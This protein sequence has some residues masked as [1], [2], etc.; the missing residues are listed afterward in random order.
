MLSNWWH[1]IPRM[2]S[3]NIST[4]TP[5]HISIPHASFWYDVLVPTIFSMM[6]NGNLYIVIYDAFSFN[7]SGNFGRPNLIELLAAAVPRLIIRLTAFCNLFRILITQKGSSLCNYMLPF[8]IP[9]SKFMRLYFYFY[10]QPIASSYIPSFQKCEKLVV[11][12][13]VF[14]FQ[15]E[16]KLCSIN[17]VDR[18]E[19]SL[20][21]RQMQLTTISLE[22]RRLPYYTKRA[23]I[24]FK[25][26]PI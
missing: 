9:R 19:M 18:K 6:T 12:G 20:E 15:Q 23:T 24:I 7:Q 10:I 2:W 14:L 3:N 8:S 1:L 22:C 26:K 21:M 5:R 16:I 17:T 4:A 25:Y 11:K 13:C